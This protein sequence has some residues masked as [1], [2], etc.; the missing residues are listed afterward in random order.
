MLA[1][2]RVM[3]Q[4]NATEEAIQRFNTLGIVS[5]IIVAA[6]WALVWWRRKK[7]NKPS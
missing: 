3:A 1:V 6:L 2:G 5:T 7:R 4:Q